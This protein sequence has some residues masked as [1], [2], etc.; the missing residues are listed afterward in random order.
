MLTTS[1]L[2]YRL[3]PPSGGF[4]PNRSI[5]LDNIRKYTGLMFVVLILLFVGL[6][7]MESSG[8][9]S[10]YGSGPVMIEISGH[11]YPKEEFDRLSS[12]PLRL[13]NDLSN[14]K[15]TKS[16]YGRFALLPY[17]MHL[18]IPE[19][20]RS[21]DPDPRHFLVNRLTLQKTA[22]ELGI[23]PST[24]EI[25]N[26]I[27]ESIFINPDQTFN[28]E[29]YDKYVDK[30]LPRLGMNIK[31]MNE[32]LR[33]VLV[34]QRLQDVLG[35]GLQA[36]PIAVRENI[37]DTEQEISYK[38]ISFPASDFEFDENP[39]DEEVKTYWEENRGRYFADAKR[40]V[41]YVIAKPDFNAALDKKKAEAAPPEEN[42]T[43]VPAAEDAAEDADADE[44]IT[45]S[46]EERDAVNRK[47]GE[48]VDAFWVKLKDSEGE[49]FEEKASEAGLEVKTTELFTI[50]NC[51]A[52]F[53]VGTQTTQRKRVVDFIFDAVEGTRPM[54]A[55]SNPLPLPS[56]QWLV[57]RLDEVIEAVELDYA[58]AKDEA[59]LDLVK[60]RSRAKMAEAAEAA[61]T[62]L[63]EAVAG[64]K[65]FEDAASE[66]EL[67]VVVR[68]SV[69]SDTQDPSEPTPTEIFNLASKVNPGETSEV[70]TQ[71]NEALSVFRSLFVNVDKRELVETNVAETAINE[72]V[73]SVS[74]EYRR[75]A[76][77]NWLAQAY[78]AADVEIPS[79]P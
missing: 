13:L 4:I 79:T 46:N 43:E 41:S 40:R 61:R 36:S 9:S 30:Y 7:F 51:P 25:E 49:G 73:K 56:N 16:F 26:F 42:P 35:S 65:S 48:R 59:R 52:E 63:L 54:D 10:G 37:A 62:K 23:H 70:L 19:G 66:Q 47:E 78:K 69:K 39:T 6:I 44:P 3:P 17:L 22:K 72:G 21:N 45:L 14:P 68:D 1:L 15:V 71:N 64:G 58:A 12:N 34:L 24:N 33:E 32:T 60:E 76:L 8:R 57:F 77:R 50:T 11:S 5:M 29:A 75:I 74:N 31:D 55:I 20:S 18:A 38:L 2:N 67:E 28:S 27:R 53:R